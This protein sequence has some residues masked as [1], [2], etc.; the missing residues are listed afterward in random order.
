MY[1]I[2]LGNVLQSSNI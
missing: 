2:T 1:Y